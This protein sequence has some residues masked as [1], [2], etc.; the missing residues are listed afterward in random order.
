M[1]RTAA[2]ALR[3]LAVQE[4]RHEAALAASTHDLEMAAQTINERVSASEEELQRNEAKNDGRFARQNA[5][6]RAWI[7]GLR[8]GSNRSDGASR[9]VEVSRS[10]RAPAVD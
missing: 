5:L 8:P 3:A 4:Q 6:L 2:A 9:L 10:A 1:N 7:S